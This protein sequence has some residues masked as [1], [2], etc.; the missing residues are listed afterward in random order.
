[1]GIKSP[2]LYWH[3]KNKSLLMEAMKPL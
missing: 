2:T 3:F 1:M